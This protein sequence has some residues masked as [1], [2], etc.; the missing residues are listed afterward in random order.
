MPFGTQSLLWLGSSAN[1]SVIYVSFPNRLS[2]QRDTRL[3]LSL[4][5]DMCVCVSVHYCVDACMCLACVWRVCV[6]FLQY[7]C[8]YSTCVFVLYSMYVCTVH[9]CFVQYMCVQYVCV[10]FVQYVCVF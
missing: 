10:C 4:T 8:V 6:C 7:V 2:L 9:V 1:R 3:P 5:T